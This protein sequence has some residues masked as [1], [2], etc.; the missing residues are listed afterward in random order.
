M[1]DFIRIRTM[2]GPFVI[3]EAANKILEKIKEEY[4]DKHLVTLSLK[5]PEL[6]KMEGVKEW[7]EECSTI[8]NEELNE[9]YLDMVCFGT[10]EIKIYKKDDKCYGNDRNNK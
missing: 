3:Q 8:V 4:K 5:D 7:L 1:L 10:S 9:A 6:E 2:K